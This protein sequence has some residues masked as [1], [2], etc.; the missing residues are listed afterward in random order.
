MD[1]KPSPLFLVVLG[2]LGTALLSPINV[3]GIPIFFLAVPMAILATILHNAE[4]G[5]VVGVG[6]SVV[7]GILVNSI[8]LWDMVGMGLAAAVVVL[9]YDAI[10]PKQKTDLSAILFAVLGALLLELTNEL[11]TRESILFRPELFLGTHPALGLQILA[12]VFAM[13][14]LLSFYNTGKK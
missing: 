2:G 6:T 10:Y 5:I 7:S 9:A 11:T 13:G 3:G 8:E 14:L 4:A 1:A 12:N